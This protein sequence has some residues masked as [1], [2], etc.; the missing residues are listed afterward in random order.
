MEPEEFTPGKIYLINQETRRFLLNF[1][2]SSFMV[3]E[4][5]EYTTYSGHDSV[6]VKVI[7]A[8]KKKSDSQVM[9]LTR[10]Y[11]HEIRA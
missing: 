3:I 5:I 2:F 6:I 1:F 9:N 4:V 8:H 7:K 11:Y 10:K